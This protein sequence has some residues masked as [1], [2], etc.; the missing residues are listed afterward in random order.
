MKYAKKPY[1]PRR[2]PYKRKSTT[3]AMR[4]LSRRIKTISLRQAETKMSSRLEENLQCTHNGTYY[5][6]GLLNTTQGT[7]D[8]TDYSTGDRVGDEI[9][10]R[11]MKIKLWM[12][13][14]LDRPNVMYH[15]Y[16]FQ[17]NTLDTP[18]NSIFWRGTGVN[19]MLDGPNS[20]RI[21][22]LKKIVVTS[23]SQ[24]GDLSTGIGGDGREHSYYRECWIPMYNRKIVYRRDGGGSPK[25]TDIGIAVTTYDAYGTPTTANIASFAFSK[26]LYFKD[27]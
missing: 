8:P 7:N 9:I 22:V 11:G 6:N 13:N 19:R 26:T 24:F 2:R 27:P 21:K 16:V 14:K 25:G 15:I 12:S 17:Y 20:E 3:P 1:R 23:G 10:A 5:V 18:T 4:T